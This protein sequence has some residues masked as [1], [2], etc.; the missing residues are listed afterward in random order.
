MGE[1]TRIKNVLF[2]VLATFVIFI[3]ILVFVRMREMGGRNDVSNPV[4]MDPATDTVESVRD[5]EEMQ[6]TEEAWEKEQK[7]AYEEYAKA[8]PVSVIGGEVVSVSESGF[9]MMV[10]ENLRYPVTGS[11]LILVAKE[12]VSLEKATCSASEGES[13]LSQSCTTETIT[14]SDLKSG[15]KV[16]VSL[17]EEV[18]KKD[19]T[20]QAKAILVQ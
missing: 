18:F 8:N 7:Q 1:Q 4:V 9:E 20:L 12:G 3:L 10:A 11:Q 2:V 17:D 13:L 15:E 6:M 19:G 14:L 16:I 5:A